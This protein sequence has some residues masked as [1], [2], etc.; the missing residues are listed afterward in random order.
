MTICAS[1]SQNLTHMYYIFAWKLVQDLHESVQVLYVSGMYYN[2]HYFQ[3]MVYYF[4]GFVMVELD[5]ACGNALVKWSI[6]RGVTLV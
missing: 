6:T 4:Y 5:L 2:F 3:Y 1:G